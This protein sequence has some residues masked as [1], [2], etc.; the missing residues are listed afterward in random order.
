M[1]ARQNVMT[2]RS[3][4]RI[5]ERVLVGVATTNDREL[6]LSLLETDIAVKS[7]AMPEQLADVIEDFRPDVFLASPVFLRNAGANTLNTLSDLRVHGATPVFA[8]VAEDE[9]DGTDLLAIVDD[10]LLRP[11]RPSELEARVRQ[12][13]ARYAD[14]QSEDLLRSGDL[15]LDPTRY[16]VQYN[17]REVLLTYTEFRLLKLLLQH[18]GK[19]ITRD[20]IMREVWE[21]DYYAGMRTV[22]VVVRRLRSKLEVGDA[23]QVIRT[24]RNVG[25][26]LLDLAPRPRPQRMAH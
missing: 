10:F 13:A 22:D 23:R 25:Y 3:T 18:Q 5:L 20:A 15:V 1:Q 19:V 26:M 9:L 6:T 7:V 17:S 11:L 2:R 16:R 8:I 24:V 21:S 4:T 12:Y 14:P